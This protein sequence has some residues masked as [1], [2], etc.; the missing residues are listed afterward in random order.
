MAIPAQLSDTWDFLHREVIW[1]HGRW[2]MWNQ[3]YFK[4]ELRVEA[5]NKVAPTFFATLQNVLLDDVQLTLSRLADPA[6]TGRRENVTLET[7]AAEIERLPEPHLAADLRQDL[8][9]FRSACATIVTRRNRRIAHYDMSV[10][11][12]V[13]Q[14]PGASISEINEA[15]ERLRLL[16]TRIYRFF[17]NSHMAY[18]MFVLHD[19][20]NNIVRAVAEALRYRELLDAGIIDSMDFHSSGKAR[21]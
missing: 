19:D 6:R 12:G 21:I 11:R 10:Q 18:E 20:A 15:L 8:S 5:L 1:L 7:L 13:E 17:M 16:M 14:L 2:S 3:L 4:S 9:A